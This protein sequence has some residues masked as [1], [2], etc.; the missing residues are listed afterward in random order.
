MH[1][2]LFKSTLGAAAG[3]SEQSNAAGEPA[4]PQVELL[5]DSAAVAGP[6]AEQH[7][8]MQQMHRVLV[9]YEAAFPQW[10]AEFERLG[11][12][13]PIEMLERLAMSAPHPHLAWY[14]FGVL[15]VRRQ[16]PQQA[17]GALS[18]R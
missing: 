16:L 3:C 7:V 17:A 12:Y 6:A 18:Q 15:A 8:L 13:A 10:F 11:D 2:Y 9:D 14:V 4:L 5:D 1:Q